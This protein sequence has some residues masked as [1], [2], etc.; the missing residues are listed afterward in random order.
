MNW[1][2]LVA[3]KFKL[4]SNLLSC[5]PLTQGAFSKLPCLSQ[6]ERVWGLDICGT[7]K[8]GWPS[9][10]ASRHPLPQGEGEQGVGAVVKQT[11]RALPLP[12]C[13]ETSACSLEV[14]ALMRGSLPRP[15]GEGG[16]RPGE[17]QPT[18]IAPQNV[19][20]PDPLPLGEGLGVRGRRVNLT[21]V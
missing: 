3:K 15:W 18:R 4:R 14:R 13:H 21:K 2:Y 11:F 10:V 9:P 16:R 1:G 7:E 6:W 20:T 17:G 5:R 8:R 12:R 19:Q